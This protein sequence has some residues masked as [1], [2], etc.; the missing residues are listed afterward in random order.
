ME[1]TGKSTEQ[2]GYT[3][4]K[5]SLSKLSGESSEKIVNR[6]FEF[7]GEWEEGTEPDDDVTLAVLKRLSS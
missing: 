6:L 2:Y 7:Y 1:A 5:E 4:F 3:R